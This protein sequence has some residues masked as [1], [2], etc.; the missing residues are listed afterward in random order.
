MLVGLG[1]AATGEVYV[2]Q[3]LDFLS[4]LAAFCAIHCL[5]G[6]LAGALFAVRAFTKS[7]N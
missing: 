6:G 5:A 7:A 4:L 3:A 1:A 2:A